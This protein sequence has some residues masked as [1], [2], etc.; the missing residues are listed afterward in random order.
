MFF[1]PEYYFVNSQKII[2][3]RNYLRR[4][5]KG[6]QTKNYVNRI[7]RFCLKIVGTI[8]WVNKIN[9]NKFKQNKTKLTENILLNQTK[10]KRPSRVCDTLSLRQ[11]RP[12]MVLTVEWRLSLR[13]QWSSQIVV[14]L[15]TTCSANQTCVLTL[16]IFFLK[17]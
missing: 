11:I 9:W 16:W 14:V 2:F 15:Q 1:Q 12:V 8:F 4:M 17:L 13:I 3:F 6:K 7:I 10:I 5:E